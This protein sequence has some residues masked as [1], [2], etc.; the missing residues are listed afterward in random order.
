MEKICPFIKEKCLEHVC[1]FYVHV[2]GI[3]PQTGA[4]MDNWDCAIAW[5]P[6]LLIEGANESRKTAASVQSFRNEMVKHQETLIRL[7]LGE[8]V[9]MI[10]HGDKA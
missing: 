6:V 1:Q 7:A 3:N 10:G 4:Q 9:P 8:E 2:Q 5:L